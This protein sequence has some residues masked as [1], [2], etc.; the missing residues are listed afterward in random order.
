MISLISLGIVSD[1]MW[2]VTSIPTFAS[3]ATRPSSSRGVLE[4]QG[5]VEAQVHVYSLD[6]PSEGSNLAIV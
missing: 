1:S 6:D 2:I 4:R 3:L 5:F